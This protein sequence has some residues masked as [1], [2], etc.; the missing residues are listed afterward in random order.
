[1]G[2]VFVPLGDLKKTC[3]A[4]KLMNLSSWLLAAPLLLAALA[5]PNAGRETP[6]PAQTAEEVGDD[7]AVVVD[8]R[9]FRD[10]IVYA[11]RG[12]TRIRLGNVPGNR[13]RRL[14]AAC[15]Q[16]RGTTTDF[17]LRSVAGRS[18]LL[19]GAAIVGCDQVYRI[20]IVPG[21]LEFSRLW[22]ESIY[23]EDS[24]EEPGDDG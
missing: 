15:G 23:R 3:K 11:E 13:I 18:V 2:P 24:E 7:Y 8:N 22:I 17:I 20:V 1:L 12:G 10:V 14:R 21:G 5:S 9:S 6:G 16:F 4:V 19:S